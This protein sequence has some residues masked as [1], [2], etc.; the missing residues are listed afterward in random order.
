[1]RAKRRGRRLSGVASGA[2]LIALKKLSVCCSHLFEPKDHQKDERSDAERNA[3]ITEAQAAIRTAGEV[4]GGKKTAGMPDFQQRRRLR[5][6]MSKFEGQIS[7]LRAEQSA[8]RDEMVDRFSKIEGALEQL[9][10]RGGGEQQ[11]ATQ[12]PA[13]DRLPPH[14]QGPRLEA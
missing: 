4:P 6:D 3:E 12:V 1:M 7:Q 13:R 8:M 2:D 10:S 11:I 5:G 14:A 9:L